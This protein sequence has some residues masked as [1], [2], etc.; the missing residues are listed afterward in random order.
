VKVV[1][2]NHGIAW[3][4]HEIDSTLEISEKSGKHS[5]STLILVI[6]RVRL[7]KNLQK[8]TLAFRGG[9]KLRKPSI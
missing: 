8:S 6:H 4:G 2:K 7:K 9:V 1:E 5:T 3:K